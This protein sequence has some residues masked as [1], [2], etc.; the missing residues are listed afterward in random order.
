[1]KLAI[2]SGEYPIDFDDTDMK[3][4]LEARFGVEVVPGTPTY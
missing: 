3:V 1:M 4:T 2:E